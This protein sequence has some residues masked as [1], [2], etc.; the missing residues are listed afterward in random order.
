MFLYARR[1]GSIEA[2]HRR[3]LRQSCTVSEQPAPS[4]S[5]PLHDPDPENWIGVDLNTTGHIAVIAHPPTGRVMK[6]GKNAGRIHAKYE[7]LRENFRKHKKA[8]KLEKI[9]DRE[10]LI[11]QDLVTRISRQVVYCAQSLHAGIKLERIYGPDPEKNP[12]DE[13]VPEYAITSRAFRKLQSLIETRAGKAGVPVVY[14][15]PAFTSKKCS[16]C[17]SM[18]IRHRKKFACPSCGYAEHADVNAAF[19]IADSPFVIDEERIAR[20]RR[21][22]AGQKVRQQL[23]ARQNARFPD[24]VT[25]EGIHARKA[26]ESIFCTLD[27]GTGR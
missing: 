10:R 20:A 25:Y 5:H 11:L 6:L 23:R 3:S 19:N 14:V 15:D 18:G 7:K 4:F 13:S 8:R 24:F 22:K 9:G 26:G 16:R 27:A 17:G 1:G 12:P 21:H 2:L